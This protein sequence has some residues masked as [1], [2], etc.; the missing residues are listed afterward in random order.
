MFEE[1]IALA[2][3]DNTDHERGLVVLFYNHQTEMKFESAKQGR[4]IYKDVIYVKILAAGQPSS[5]VDR[6]AKDPDFDKY[7]KAWA[8][9]Q[10][11]TERIEGTPIGEWQSVSRSRAAELAHIGVLTVEL[12][13]EVNDANIENLGPDGRAL[14]ELAR[15]ALVNEGQKDVELQEL[16]DR[17]TS[18]ETELKA[19]HAKPTRKKPGPTPRNVTAND[20][21]DNSTEH[22]ERNTG[23]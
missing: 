19:A 20:P 9:Y 8:R 13:S 16:R 2:K 3:Q 17:V 10:S 15:K 14:R 18:L 4:P 7:P 5:T 12:L 1:A 22:A 21:S 11:K 6:K 23:V